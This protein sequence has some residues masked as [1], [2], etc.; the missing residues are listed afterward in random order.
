MQPYL[1]ICGKQKIAR[2]F[3]AKDDE[4]ALR[5]ASIFFSE[6][7]RIA[8][9]FGGIIFDDEKNPLHPDH[10]VFAKDHS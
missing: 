9:P 10:P 8:K 5:V 3:T 7:V 6:V 2:D 4:D 1:A